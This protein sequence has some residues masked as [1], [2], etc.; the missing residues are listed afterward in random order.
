M[1]RVLVATCGNAHAGDDAFGPMVGR[2]LRDSTHSDFEVVDL[3]IK[4]AALLDHLPGPDCL[5]LVD[6]LAPAPLPIAR[7]R[8]RVCTVDL[9][10]ES[11][12]S[13]ANEDVLSSHG[14]GLAD[15]LALADQLGILPVRVWLVG[16]IVDATQ[17]GAAASAWMRSAVEAAA[18][19][20]AELA[21]EARGGEH[22]RITPTDHIF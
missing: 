4:P 10:R 22:Q 19:R 13:L 14:L 21:A 2:H 7:G 20:V 9:S 8:D 17:V 6:A 11:L 18:G 15:Q 5:I 3:D 12:P 1:T 16:A